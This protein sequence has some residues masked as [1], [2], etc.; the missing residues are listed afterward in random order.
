[1]NYLPRKVDL[2][3]KSVDKDQQNLQIGEWGVANSNLA[4]MKKITE[5]HSIIQQGFKQ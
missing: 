1:M 4:K 5:L 3:A 2:F